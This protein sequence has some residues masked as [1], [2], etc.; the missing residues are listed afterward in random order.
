MYEGSKLLLQNDNHKKQAAIMLE[1]TIKYGGK[2]LA[3]MGL[4]ED[5]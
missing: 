5:F 1:L 2:I 4:L 3:E